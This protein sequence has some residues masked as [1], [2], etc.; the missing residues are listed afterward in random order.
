LYNLYNLIKIKESEQKYLLTTN[1]SKSFFIN[2]YNRLNKIKRFILN[3]YFKNRIKSLSKRTLNCLSNIYIDNNFQNFYKEVSKPEFSV[4]DLKNAGK[5]TEQEFNDFIKDIGKLSYL[6]QSQANAQ[7]FYSFFVSVVVKNLGVNEKY[8]EKFS[9]DFLDYRFPLFSFINLLINKGYLYHERELKIFYHRF[10]YYI[11]KEIFTLEKLSEKLSK[12]NQEKLTRERVRQLSLKI[13]PT[14]EGKLS[15]LFICFPYTN[16]EISFQEDQDIIYINN[17]FADRINISENVKFT[18]KFYTKIFSIFIGATHKLFPDNLRDEANIYLIKQEL[19]EYFD[20]IAFYLDIEQT[21]NSVI[22][23]SYSIHFEGYLYNFLKV[24]DLQL[25]EKILPICELIVFEDF[26][27]FIDIEGNLIF[28]R[29]TRKIIDD[30]S[31]TI[32]ITH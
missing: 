22:P 29:N 8:I 26:N 1:E 27:L 25:L 20:F 28:D 13:N 11:D 16:Y 10:N 18:S 17:E 19:F 31:T 32:I 24:E 15:H 6:L 2:Y 7:D 4:K 30:L 12:P 14:L 5:K 21:V 3:Q 23:E 9:S